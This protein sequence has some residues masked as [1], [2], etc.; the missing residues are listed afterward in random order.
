MLRAVGDVIA[1]PADRISALCAAVTADKPIAELV[2]FM[3]VDGM[4]RLT[5]AGLELWL[6]PDETERIAARGVV[7]AHHAKGMG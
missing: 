6:T 3:P 2:E 4:V 1:F 5:V 7:A